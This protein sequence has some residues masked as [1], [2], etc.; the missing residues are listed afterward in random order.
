MTGCNRLILAGE[1]LADVLY[2]PGIS[3]T[4][5]YIKLRDNQQVPAYFHK[6][7]R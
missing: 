4:G 7:L 5:I 1:A 3:G 2:H 6:P